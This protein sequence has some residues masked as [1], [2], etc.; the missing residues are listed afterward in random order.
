MSGNRGLPV[1]KPLP[2][3]GGSV[4]RTGKVNPGYNPHWQ[5]KNHYRFQ[6]LIIS[7]IGKFGITA[8][9]FQIPKPSRLTTAQYFFY[10]TQRS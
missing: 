7:H 3:A 1:G 8:H 2:T 10:F 6:I 4:A 5:I 9:P